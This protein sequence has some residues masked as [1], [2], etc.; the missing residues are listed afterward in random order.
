MA[1][2]DFTPTPAFRPA[3]PK[4]RMTVYFALLII[5]FFAMIAA[6]LFMYLEIGRYGGFGVVPRTVS[7]VQRSTPAMFA[8]VDAAI[9]APLAT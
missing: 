9:C 4:A 7:S 3:A 2:V 5:A 1:Q 8:G 6:C